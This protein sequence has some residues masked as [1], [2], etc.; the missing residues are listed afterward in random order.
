MRRWQLRVGAAAGMHVLCGPAWVAHRGEGQG[1]MCWRDVVGRRRRA[2]EPHVPHGWRRRSVAAPHD[3]L[4]VGG[5]CGGPAVGARL[6][7]A[8]VPRQVPE[9]FRVQWQKESKCSTSLG[10]IPSSSS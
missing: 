10:K 1:G 4:V 6:T 7:W 2:R 5:L 3:P 9:G 8:Y